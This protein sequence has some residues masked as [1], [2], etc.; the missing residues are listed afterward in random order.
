[1][2]V[3]P[4]RCG[5]R[6]GAFTCRGEPCRT[7]TQFC[8][9]SSPLLRG[10]TPAFDNLT[11]VLETGRADL[12]RPQGT[13]KIALL[14]LIGGELVHSTGTVVT[15]SNANFLPQKLTLCTEQ[16]VIEMLGLAQRRRGT[17]GTGTFSSRSSRR[18][19]RAPNV[20]FA[21]P[22]SGSPPRRAS[23]SRRN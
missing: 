4:S 12:L 3:I 1:M 9:P 11:A 18:T 13:G 6:L 15:S 14:C 8:C 17:A 16:T 20:W 7:P 2:H 22:V 23:G 19:E 5:P 10:T 21:M